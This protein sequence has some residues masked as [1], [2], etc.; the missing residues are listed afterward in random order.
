MVAI[1]QLPPHNWN[2]PRTHENALSAPMTAIEYP[3]TPTRHV[4]VT[5][6]WF[7]RRVDTWFIWDRTAEKVMDE[8]AQHY[9]FVNSAFTQSQCLKL[10]RE[11][12]WSVYRKDIA[13]ASDPF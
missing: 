12:A 10:A 9:A 7:G 1:E 3:I 11:Y 5:N 4:I 6:T 8:A 13:F 2:V